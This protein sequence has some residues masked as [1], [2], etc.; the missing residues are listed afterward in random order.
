MKIQCEDSL[1]LFCDNKSTMHNSVQHDITQ[2]IEIERYSI[3]KNLD[4]HSIKKTWYI[5]EKIINY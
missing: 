4:K 3:K 5:L 1:K 2:D